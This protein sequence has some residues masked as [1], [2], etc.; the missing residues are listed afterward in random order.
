MITVHRDGDLHRWC[1]MGAPATVL[2]NCVSFRTGDQTLPLDEEARKT[3]MSMNEAMAAQ[4]LRVLA[5]AD[6]KAATDE[7]DPDHHFVFLGFVGMVDPP[8]QG[9]LEAV[10][11]ARA[12]GL[13][14]V[15]L[16]GDQI[17]TARA[18]ARELKLSD[19]EPRVLHARELIDASENQ[20]EKLARDTDVFARVS[21]EEKYRVV[22]ALQRCG[23]IVALTGDGVNDAPALKRADVGIAMGKRGT[24]VA[25]E[26]A[27]IVL[28]D[29]NFSTIVSAIEGGRAIYANIVRFVHMMFSHN[30]NEVLSIFI[31]I[32]VGWPLP[33]FPLQ[34]LWLNLV[35]DVFPSFAL[36]LEPASP[37]AMRLPPRSPRQ[38]MLSPR[39]LWLVVWQAGVLATI[40]LSAY[41]WALGRYGEGAHARTVAMIALV[42]VQVGHLFNCRSRARSA[43]DGILRNPHLW[44]A[45]AT[46]LALQL[47]ALEFTP[48][49]RILGVVPPNRADWIVFALAIILPVV[50]VELQKVVLRRMDPTA[51]LAD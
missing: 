34:I 31:A 1:L 11:T 46:V 50:V 9:V 4:A 44:F 37:Y 19:G 20:I 30:L 41:Y 8:R 3:F 13:R 28:A 10:A 7:V 36:A 47:I 51:V 5:I 33:L 17:D 32:A 35:T 26:A 14:I 29:D 23:E 45:S 42:G 43:F 49:Q 18:V 25:K 16:T 21:P 2:A 39:F 6:K 40:T 22:E 38:A 12:A 48:L 24:E 27:D 15:M